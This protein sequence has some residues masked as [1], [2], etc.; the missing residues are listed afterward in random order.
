MFEGQ[1]A[2]QLLTGSMSGTENKHCRCAQSAADL[3]K[4]F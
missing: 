3:C 4:D 1:T 2:E